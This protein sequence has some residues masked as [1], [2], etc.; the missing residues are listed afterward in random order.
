MITDTNILENEVLRTSVEN[1]LSDFLA[2]QGVVVSGLEVTH[3]DNYGEN[4]YRIHYNYENEKDE[5]R[6]GNDWFTFDIYGNQIFDLKR[7]EK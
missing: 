5:W 3:V 6:C 2:E 4:E 7:S 1:R